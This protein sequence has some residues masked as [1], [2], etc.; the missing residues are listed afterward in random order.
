M[1]LE[2]KSISPLRGVFFVPEVVLTNG[3]LHSS[4]NVYHPCPYQM[5]ERIFSFALML[6]MAVSVMTLAYQPESPP[7]SDDV[8]YPLS[9]GEN[10]LNAVAVIAPTSV[11]VAVHAVETVAMETLLLDE[12]KRIGR[13]IKLKQASISSSL[14]GYRDLHYDPGLCSSVHV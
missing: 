1:G 3:Q 14:F 10:H 12:P 9:N 8:S 7:I 6:L 2:R 4:N 11:T 5:K 13:S